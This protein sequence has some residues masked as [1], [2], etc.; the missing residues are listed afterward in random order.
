MAIDQFCPPLSEA[1]TGL[2][3]VEKPCLEHRVVHCCRGWARGTQPVT[4]QSRAPEDVEWVCQWY[5]NAAIYA[6]C[7]RVLAFHFS[8]GTLLPGGQVRV[9]QRRIL[10][11]ETWRGTKPQD[12]R[13][14]YV[15]SKFGYSTKIFVTIQFGNSHLPVSH[16]NIWIVKIYNTELS[17][18]LSFLI[19]M[20]N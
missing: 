4:S 11:P 13:P 15:D 17:F 18:Y 9:S 8:G 10:E 19:W 5:N 20:W 16:L 7:E 2:P 3:A 14:R 1:R 6:I 12:P